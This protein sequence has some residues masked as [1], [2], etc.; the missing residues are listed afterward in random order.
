MNRIVA[1]FEAKF[2]MRH[3][4]WSGKHRRGLIGRE[5]DIVGLSLGED[6]VNI[7]SRT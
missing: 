5:I 4:I 3:N 7:R 1:S 2:M 6:T